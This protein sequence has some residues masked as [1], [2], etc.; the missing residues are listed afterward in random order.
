MSNLYDYVYEL[1]LPEK[2]EL[3]WN[4][5]YNTEGMTLDQDALWLELS[6]GIGIDAGAYG[7]RDKLLR[8][9]VVY[10]HYGSWESIEHSLCR[11][12]EEIAREVER[13]ANKYLDSFLLERA[14]EIAL[15]RAKKLWKKRNKK[16]PF[17]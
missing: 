11:S 4:H 17:E 1:K 8:V 6:N 16:W 9:D 12:T 13:L 3:H 14:K 2:T 10:C 5:L 7:R 15:S